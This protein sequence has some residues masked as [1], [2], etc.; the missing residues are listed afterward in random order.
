MKV[1]IT[2]GAGQ[3]GTALQ[4]T[5]PDSVGILAPPRTEFDLA[6]LDG[7]CPALDRF[8]PQVLINAAA[9][10]DVD[11]AEDNPAAAMRINADAPGILAEWCAE[12]GARF[13]QI[14][15][16]FIFGGNDEYAPLSPG[17]SIAPI[18]VYGQTK[19]AGET[20]V[21]DADHNAT[22]LRTSWLYGPRFGT[23]FVDRMLRLA[24]TRTEISAVTDQIGSPTSAIALA[25]I[26][27]RCLESGRGMG[28]T[29][30]GVCKGA[31]SRFDLVSSA[32]DFARS[33]GVR[34]A[35]REVRPTTSDAFPTPARRPA[36][37]ALDPK[38]T[39][40]ML[41]ITVPDWKSALSDHIA[42]ILPRL[43]EEGDQP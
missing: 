28:E 16:D 13:I 36:W 10:T 35:C 20:A 24:L 29:H 15:T 3:L 34:F 22:I 6:H 9:F 38:S 8:A 1:L 30:H 39:E 4:Q 37:S 21:R 33:K 43:A 23:G 26:V 14:S 2:G 5:K 41:G 25:R 17:A 12:Y 40:E 19:A 27:W 11:G 42:S 31:A 18:S 7:L 32:F